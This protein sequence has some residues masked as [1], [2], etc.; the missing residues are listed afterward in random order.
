MVIPANAINTI[1]QGGNIWSLFFCINRLKLELPYFNYYVNLWPEK[2][3][4]YP[5][6]SPKL[7]NLL[8]KLNPGIHWH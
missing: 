3:L 8:T 6:Y 4:H 2:A 5:N 7:L 1:P